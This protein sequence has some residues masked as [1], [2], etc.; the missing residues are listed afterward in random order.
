LRG[1]DE[2]FAAV[3]SRFERYRFVG[4]ADA[5]GFAE[6]MASLLAES[7]EKAASKV[8]GIRVLMRKDKEPAEVYC[9]LSL[10][11]PLP[12]SKTNPFWVFGFFFFGLGMGVMNL[13][14]RRESIIFWVGCP[15]S[16]SSQCRAG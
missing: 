6:D 8:P 13:A 12:S 9:C 5:T 15:D 1:E 2:S 11:K 7:A 3:R 16:S 10:D 4:A 14:L